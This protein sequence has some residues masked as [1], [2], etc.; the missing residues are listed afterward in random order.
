[1]KA[2]RTLV[3]FAAIVGG[4]HALAP[5][6]GLAAV[7]GDLPP[8]IASLVEEA[9]AAREAADYAKAVDTYTKIL[10]TADLD[11]ET[12]AYVYQQ[13]GIAHQKKGSPA[14]AIADFTNTI[15]LSSVG[16][17][18]L[19]ETFVYRG[20][21][22]LALGQL[23]RA[24]HDFDTA[25]D[26]NRQASEAYFGRATAKR[27]RGEPDQALADY[28]RAL[29]LGA[30][31]PHL[32]LFGR[33][34]AREDLDSPG[35]AIDDFTEALRLRPDFVPAQAELMALD[36]PLPDTEGLAVVA[37]RPEA[38]APLSVADAG[39][40]VARSH[41]E[42]ATGAI[43]PAALA[44][45][46]GELRSG[47]VSG[48][49]DEERGDTMP[50]FSAPTSRPIKGPREEGLLTPPFLRPAADG[51]LA[52]EGG[53]G[54]DDAGDSG[55]TGAVGQAG[56]GQDEPFAV[57]ELGPITAPDEPGAEETG[58][59][60]ADG[61]ETAAIKPLLGVDEPVPS[62]GERTALYETTP[63]DPA[64]AAQSARDGFYV[65]LGSY[66]QRRFAEEGQAL[67]AEM[68]PALTQAGT[69]DIQTADL[70]DQGVFFRLRLGPYGSE[71]E[72]RSI[73]GQLRDAGQDCLVTSR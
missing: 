58:I 59:T 17:Q 43:A 9:G 44:A 45:S 28:D 24:V 34:L 7:P 41:D 70:G 51:Q 16:P 71:D 12:L 66:S 62:V 37:A 3:L 20:I 32:V 18:M 14:A 36:A 5:G 39:A 65:Q 2:S 1:M 64:P 35:M 33:G 6:F 68:F 48:A 22:Y 50:E 69:F 53:D 15:W 38:A 60:V 27:L 47:S 13:R 21:A 55:A 52:A 63:S 61:M 23:N 56:A 4:F 54:E 46:Q 25:I 57:A 19:A 73:C 49:F 29:E 72:S 42:E 26:K 8:A 30:L 67:F 11:A 31:E 40:A 10:Q